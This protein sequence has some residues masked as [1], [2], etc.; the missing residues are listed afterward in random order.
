MINIWQNDIQEL[1]TPWFVVKTIGP[2]Y[3]EDKK[4]GHIKWFDS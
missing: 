4:E 2:I 1:M 3:L